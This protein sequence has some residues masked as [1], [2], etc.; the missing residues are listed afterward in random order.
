MLPPTLDIP[1]SA[2]GV[3]A[4]EL[5]D[6]IQATVSLSASTQAG[7]TI[8]ITA[9][10]GI[11]NF[12]TT[13]SVSAGDIIAGESIVTLTG[14]ASFADGSY[15][16]SAF[17][18]T[19][20]NNSNSSNVVIFSI[21]A[22]NDPPEV[23]ATLTN[24]LGLVG[25]EALNL[26]DMKDQDLAAF[27]RNGNLQT[28]VIEYSSV[29]NLS[30][31]AVTL[32]ASLALAAELG[33]QFTVVSD[34]GTVN[35]IAATSTMT[36]TAIGGGTIDNQS[37]NEFLA[38]VTFNEGLVSLAVL[39]ATT[40]TATDSDGATSSDSASSLASVGLLNGDVSLIEKTIGDDIFVGTTAN[41]RMYGYA[42]NDTISGGDGNDLIRG[43]AGDDTLNGDDGNDLLI[44]GDGND[45]LNG[46]AGNDLLIITDAVF[47]ALDGGDGYD[48]L[49]LDGGF[50]LDLTGVINISNIE[51]I[52]LGTGDTGCTLTL[53]EAAVTSLTDIANQL[54][55]SGEANDTVNLIGAIFTGGTTTDANGLVYD[56]YTFGV[57]QV[58]IDQDIQVFI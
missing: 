10:D 7:D 9:N 40:I 37:I 11:T 16:A 41:D 31:G 15:T 39:D 58:F 42:G 2:G 43:G 3:N 45:T 25:V 8:T 32:S 51:Q 22:V 27:D 4:T 47:A 38:S 12:I 5:S 28:V 20:G 33:L 52:D 53:T 13:Y 44:G 6:G 14:S 55:V 57:N 18:T 48:I 17:I 49:Q 54:Y 23:Q 19:G 36:I 21:D 26:I 50:P 1:E 30:L 24:L 29:L 35:I 56:S 46:G 34:P